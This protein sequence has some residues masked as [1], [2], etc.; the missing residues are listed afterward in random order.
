MLK[1]D[2]QRHKDNH[3]SFRPI[4]TH[5]LELELEQLPWIAWPQ[6]DSVNNWKNL[7]LL[8]E[9]GKGVKNSGEAL[10]FDV[11]ESVEKRIKCEESMVYASF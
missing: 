5:P 4:Q 7:R 11:A 8:P 3:D 1:N 2:W 9:E 6:N 10:S